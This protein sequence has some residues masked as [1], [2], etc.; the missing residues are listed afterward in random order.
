MKKVIFILST[1]FVLGMIISGCG[2]D[3]SDHTAEAGAT[4]NLYFR[5]VDSIEYVTVPYQLKSNDAKSCVVDVMKHLLDRTQTVEDGYTSPAPEGLKTNSVKFDQSQFNIDFNEV[6]QSMNSTDEMFFRTCAVLSLTQIEGVNSVDFLINGEQLMNNS[7]DIIGPMHERDF[8][9]EDLHGTIYKDTKEVSLYYASKDGK[10]LVEVKKDITNEIGES[11]EE[12]ALYALSEKV[13]DKEP[14]MAPLP[15]NLR[16]NS[17]AIN[18]GTCFI[19]LSDDIMDSVSGVNSKTTVFAM[20]DTL[21]DMNGASNVSF[22]VNGESVNVLN[23][24][25]GFQSLIGFD[26]QIIAGQN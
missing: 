1:I 16:I 17:F 6:Y 14:Y 20:V 12:A 4:I 7:G 22:T 3:A 9:I 5:S 24:Y 26:Y 23:D 8:V 2:N 18:G 15:E 21:I 13:D 25:E 19:D 10:H 11:M